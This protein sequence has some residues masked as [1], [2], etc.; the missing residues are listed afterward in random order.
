MSTLELVVGVVLLL[1]A[2]RQWR[3]R[4]RHGAEA[5]VPRWLLAADRS[6]PPRAFATGMVLVLANPKNLTLTVAAA[7]AVAGAVQPTGERVT[8]LCC[9]RRWARR[10]WSS[11]S[12]CGSRG[13]SRAVGLLASWRRWLVLHGTVVACAVLVLIGALLVI[14]GAAAW[15]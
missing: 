6:T 10:G 1:L 4:P 14:R 8:A 12:A 2:V 9:S 3:R 11:R 7:G 13:G 5:K 15:A